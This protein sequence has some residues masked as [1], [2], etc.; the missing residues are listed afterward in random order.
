MV[1]RKDSLAYVEFIRGKYKL[2]N[3]SYIQQLLQSMTREELDCIEQLDF[4]HLWKKLWTYGSNKCYAKEQQESEIK[5]AKLKAGYTLIDPTT[6]ESRVIKVQDL[7]QSTQEC[8]AETEWGWPKGRRNLMESDKS[9]ATRE[10]REETGI[11]PSNIRIRFEKPV[12]E[13]FMGSNQVRYKH[14]Y[15][16]AEYI[17]NK[18]G[19][20]EMPQ[21]ITHGFQVSEIK[22]VR[23]FTYDAANQKLINS[24]IEKRELLKRVNNLILRRNACFDLPTNG[25]QPS[26]KTWETIQSE[27]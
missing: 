24:N 7:V 18:M 2:E 9:C 15:Y 19:V 22:S 5:L 16:I 25:M 11:R 4:P 12:E 23:W 3:V 14:V 1:Q 26:K 6:N 8:L 21:E 20:G 17:P 10:F 13:V 27:S